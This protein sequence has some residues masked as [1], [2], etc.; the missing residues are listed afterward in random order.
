MKHSY[1]NRGFEIVTFEDYYDKSCSIQQSS[2]A[3]EDCI[4]LGLDDAEPKIMA[5]VA[6]KYGIHT[7]ETT[8][9]VDYPIP[10]EVLLSTRMHLNREQVQELVKKLNNW[11]ETGSFAKK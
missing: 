6:L 9:W 8:G 7:A 3:T 4:W 11:L 10:D 2:L 1:T 5:S